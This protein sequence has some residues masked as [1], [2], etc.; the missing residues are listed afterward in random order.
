M[1]KH[2]CPG[3]IVR[4][5]KVS[6]LEGVPIGDDDEKARDAEG[7]EVGNDWGFGRCPTV[8]MAIY[9]T[10]V[11]FHMDNFYRDYGRV[12][13]AAG[14]L[15][16]VQ[17]ELESL[18]LATSDRED[19]EVWGF[20]QGQLVVGWR[21]LVENSAFADSQWVDQVLAEQNPMQLRDAAMNSWGPI[22]KLHYQLHRVLDVLVTTGLGLNSQVQAEEQQRRAAAEIDEM[23][24]KWRLDG[25]E[26][27]RS[28]IHDLENDAFVAQTKTDIW[29]MV[30]EQV[31]RDF[32]P[33]LNFD[34][35]TK[36]VTHLLGK[37]QVMQPRL[38]TITADNYEDYQFREHDISKTFML[39]CHV[40]DP[41]ALIQ[42]LRKLTIDALTLQ[43][44]NA[45][46]NI[47]ASL[48][49]LGARQLRARSPIQ[50]P[51]RLGHEPSQLA[52]P[53]GFMSR[54][55][56]VLNLTDNGRLL[57]PRGSGAFRA[58]WIRPSVREYPQAQAM[59]D[60]PSDALIERM[61]PTF[62]LYETEDGWWA[63]TIEGARRGTE[64]VF[65]GRSEEMVRSIATELCVRQ[66]ALVE[67]VRRE[68]EWLIRL[69]DRIRAK[70]AVDQAYPNQEFVVVTEWMRE[71]LAG[72]TGNSADLVNAMA[73]IV[74][75]ADLFC[76]HASDSDFYHLALTCKTLFPP[77]ARF[78]W[79]T[80]TITT[81]QTAQLLARTLSQ[82][83]ATTTLDYHD[84]V[85]AFD[86]RLIL[87]EYQ[88][89]CVSLFSPFRFP[90]LVRIRLLISNV[91]L[92]SFTPLFQAS[93]NSLTELVHS[94]PV[95]ED[96]AELLLTIPRDRLKTY[97]APYRGYPD[98][99]IDLIKQHSRSLRS[100]ELSW[101]YDTIMLAL[102]RCDGLEEI[103]L[104]AF[105]GSRAVAS[106]VR[107]YVRDWWDLNDGHV[108]LLA[109]R[110]GALARY[111]TNLE[112]FETDHIEQITTHCRHLRELR[113][114]T[115]PLHID[116]ALHPLL[117]ASSRTT[118]LETLVLATSHL[119]PS[120][121]RRFLL[122]MPR[123]RELGPGPGWDEDALEGLAMEVEGWAREGR[124]V[125]KR[126]SG[127]GDERWLTGNKMVAERKREEG[128]ARGGMI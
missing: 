126:G 15:K 2:I 90:H 108:E 19:A 91:P 82:P 1:N 128:G 114:S 115:T 121:A 85:H 51:E 13:Q 48:A 76:A 41:A 62:N 80:L 68:Q 8:A 20:C 83:A 71:Y 25:E 70:R 110:K 92:K 107:L 111:C 46:E 88:P 11:A 124:M 49:F 27:A 23:L 98:T 21:D 93:R 47:F 67:M 102:A 37:K 3:E 97:C 58:D 87:P 32:D 40:G 26:L 61:L 57:D 86:C 103:S 22:L 45:H 116:T 78:L 106:L 42:S 84:L 118:T 6:T 72:L 52:V 4:R 17:D 104:T 39:L 113:I 28:L 33:E 7:V 123:L 120:F 66:A 60:G 16:R 94:F 12:S 35:V 122:E 79:H 64:A 74:G 55:H 109:Q 14:D 117:D 30:D 89:L 96:F 101:A 36:S 29:R 56:L 38:V 65:A 112:V 9:V 127:A 18:L 43:T 10:A 54:A 75:L 95:T 53:A 81:E 125:T 99:T 50:A 63:V 31:M 5:F 77:A 69:E 119:S 24:G 105:C 34:T 100:V 59:I 44:C 73:D